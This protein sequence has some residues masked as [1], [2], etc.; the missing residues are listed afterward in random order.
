MNPQEVRSV[1]SSAVQLFRHVQ[2]SCT[3]ADEKGAISCYEG[4]I[5]AFVEAELDR[6]YGN[7]FSSMVYLRAY[8]K[9]APDTCSYVARNGAEVVAIFLFC[10]KGKSVRVLNEGM[11]S[12]E[13]E[14]NR[15]ATFVF[16]RYNAVETIFFRAVSFG[17][18]SGTS[19]LHFPFHRS[20][21]PG[22]VVAELPSIADDY[23]TGLGKN[24]RK[25]IRRNERK[26]KESFPSFQ[27]DFHDG[28]RINEAHIRRIIELNKARMLETGNDYR[29]NEAEVQGLLALT[30]A[31]GLVGVATIDGQVCAGTIG[32]RIGDTCTGRI[33]AHDPRYN[34]YG[35]GL[36][37]AYF[38]TRESILRGSRHF[39]FMSG[40]NEFKN[41]LGGRLQDQENRVIYRSRLC[42]IKHARVGLTMMGQ[43]LAFNTISAMQEKIRDLEREEAQQRS[44]MRSR[45]ALYSLKTIRR[46]KQVLSRLGKKD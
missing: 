2:P 38:A 8:N 15:F 43:R 18:E 6:L 22:D 41:M 40:N 42:A 25:N 11:K 27:L 23:L 29:R 44:D 28:A 19:R 46:V 35:I 37:C 9:L 36:L 26:I 16:S 10:R 14:A 21:S 32:L 39:N 3:V 17:A 24:S 31:Y 12:S 20:G 34:S 1:N 7:L 4:E 45:A 13:D 5:P 30:K 33:I